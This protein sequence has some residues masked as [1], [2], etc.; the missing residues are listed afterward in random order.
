MSCAK[1][2]RVLRDIF[3]ILQLFIHPNTIILGPKHPP[4]SSFLFSLLTHAQILLSSSSFLFSL[5]HINPSE[6]SPSSNPTQK[7]QIHIHNTNPQIHIHNTNPQ[8]HTPTWIQ[9]WIFQ[10]LHGQSSPILSKS[11]LNSK[12]KMK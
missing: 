11:S 6:F 8:S 4:S 2:M 10:D 9:N 1:H 3:G 5:P 12:P 7:P